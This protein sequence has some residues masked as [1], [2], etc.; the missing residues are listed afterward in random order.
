MSSCG[1]CKGS[2]TYLIIAEGAMFVDTAETR[3]SLKEL[4]LTQ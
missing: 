2:D 1:R 3:E 4:H